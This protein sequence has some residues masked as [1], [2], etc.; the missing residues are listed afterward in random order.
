V[1]AVRDQPHEDAVDVR[2]PG[3]S[4]LVVEVGQHLVQEIVQFLRG[5][6]AGRV[7]A[8]RLVGRV[9][10]ERLVLAVGSDERGRQG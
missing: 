7:D 2:V 3:A 4:V 5:E 1:G 9:V 6:V 10:V 8:A